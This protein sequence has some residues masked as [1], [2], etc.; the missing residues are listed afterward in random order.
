MDCTDFYL[1][2]WLPPYPSQVAALFGA[3]G[4]LSVGWTTWLVGCLVVARRGGWLAA[5][6]LACGGAVMVLAAFLGRPV[7]PS[8]RAAGWVGYHVCGIAVFHRDLVAFYPDDTWVWLAV[9]TGMGLAGLALIGWRP[10]LPEE[11]R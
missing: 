3:L 4:V 5:A 1:P 9:G 11:E 6:L 7:L 10:A 8:I 2:P